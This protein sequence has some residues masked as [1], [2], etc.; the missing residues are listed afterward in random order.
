VADQE[1]R[2]AESWQNHLED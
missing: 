1:T 2:M